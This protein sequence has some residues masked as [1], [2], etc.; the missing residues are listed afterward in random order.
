MYF[1]VLAAMY[2]ESSDLKW[3]NYINRQDV[4]CLFPDGNYLWIGTQDA[5]L[6]RRNCLTGEETVFDKDEG[7]F[8]DQIIALVR[9][10]GNVVW[11]ASPYDIACFRNGS[12]VVENLFDDNVNGMTVDSSGTVWIACSNGVGRRSGDGFVKVNDFD[13][14][15][16]ADEYPNAIVSGSGAGIVYVLVRNRV[17]CFAVDGMY[18]RSIAIPFENPM[19]LCTDNENRLFVAGVDTV[20]LFENETWRFFREATA[21]LP[22]V[23]LR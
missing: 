20:G 3:K 21:R 18:C 6:V 2:G 1:I 9:D 12:W 13:S 10:S 16:S 4:R 11:A 14:I 23:R 19:S 7:F 5:G 17:V 15:K 8:S 22:S